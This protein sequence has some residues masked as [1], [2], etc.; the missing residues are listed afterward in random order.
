MDDGIYLP[1]RGSKL[2]TR[3]HCAHWEACEAE[4][5]GQVKA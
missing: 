5:V 3:R 1:N 4:Y 2:C